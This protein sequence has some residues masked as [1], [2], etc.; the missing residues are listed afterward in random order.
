MNPSAVHNRHDLARH[1]QS[2]MVAAHLPFPSRE[3]GDFEAEGRTAVKTYLLEAHAADAPTREAEKFLKK[4]ARALSVKVLETEDDALFRLSGPVGD[5][6]C[7]TSMG[8]YWRLHSTAPVDKADE[9]RDRLVSA[10]PWLDNVWLPPSMLENLPRDTGSE[11]KTF[12]LSHN[13]T[14]LTD[15]EAGEGELDYVSMRLWA[16]RAAETL[17][18]LR[19]NDI[20]PRGV[21]IRSVRIRSGR[22]EDGDDF[23]ISE[24]FHT[25]KVTASGSSFDAHTALT[26][27]VLNRYRELVEGIEARYGL[28]RCGEPTRLV[29]KPVVV[30]TKWT[31]PSFEYAVARMF[32][33]VEPFRL[34]GV[35][36][37]VGPKRY[38]THAVDLH[39]GQTLTFDVTPT[40][41]VIQ[42]PR[43]TCGNTV[44]RF[45]AGLQY[46][47]D[48]EAGQ[49]VIH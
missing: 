5:V 31:V 24:Y 17:S 46:H 8:R 38:R 1:L 29:G 33:A 3:G 48:S 20:F 15:S 14:P 30:Q 25:G 13:R 47:L 36:E 49:D 2:Q 44:V 28:G 7:D 23:C 41:V 21:S 39:V 37:K 22:D 43:G 11:M 35:P 19:R 18:K 45:I 32:A 6:W 4:V 10:S 16:S 26:V 9:F 34:W 40:S 27:H 12:S 42:L